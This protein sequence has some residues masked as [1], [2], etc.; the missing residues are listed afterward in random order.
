M[1]PPRTIRCKHCGREV[2][3]NPRVKDQGY[4]ARPECQK[5]RKRCWL[6]RK[7][8]QDP[9]YGQMRRDSRRK[10]RQEHPDYWRRWRRGHRDYVERNRILQGVRN[11]KR[12]V[13]KQGDCKVDAF[14]PPVNTEESGMVSSLIAKYDALAE[15]VKQIQ[16]VIGVVP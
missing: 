9:D 3:A 12:R 16:L 14:K 15:K 10:W 7:L 4:C 2:P 11:K 13:C 6:Q 8:A 1:P 5:A